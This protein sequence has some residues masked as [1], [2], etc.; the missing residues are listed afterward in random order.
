[1]SKLYKHFCKE[2]GLTPN[3]K[4]FYQCIEIDAKDISL[5]GC[6]REAA[7]VRMIMAYNFTVSILNNSVGQIWTAIQ[8]SKQ[9]R[10]DT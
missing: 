3:E 10:K 5:P 9:I 1:M 8:K 6:P 4:E 2:T 7:C